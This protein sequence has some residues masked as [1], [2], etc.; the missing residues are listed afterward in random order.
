[1]MTSPQPEDTVD[2]TTSANDL[3]DL[4]RRIEQHSQQLS[5]HGQQLRR[6]RSDVDELDRRLKSA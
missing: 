3:A 2:P 1:M 6:L 4:Q 5:R